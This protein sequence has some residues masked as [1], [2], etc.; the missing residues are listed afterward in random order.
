MLLSGVW[1]NGSKIASSRYTEITP[2][3]PLPFSSHHLL[4]LNLSQWH[5]FQRFRAKLMQYVFSIQGQR[6]LFL[7]FHRL[8]F[9]WIDEWY[10]MTMLQIREKEM[11]TDLLLK[12][13]SS[14]YIKLLITSACSLPYAKLKFVRQWS[15][16]QFCIQCSGS[17]TCNDWCYC[18]HWKNLQRLGA[19]MR[20]FF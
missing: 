1:A 20:I 16:L 9:A 11:Q 13:V 6:A 8:C 18:R 14:Q 19:S 5:S 2:V 3:V 4:S 10:G 12:K 17:D 15:T 7:A